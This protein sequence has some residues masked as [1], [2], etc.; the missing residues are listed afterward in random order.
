M[1]TDNDVLPYV[2]AIMKK[3]T[4]ISAGALISE[5]WILT[6]GDALYLFRENARELRVRLGSI[7]YRRGGIL[8]PIKQF[9]IHPYF[10]DTSPEYDIAL[11]KLPKPVRFTS[12]IYPIRV[13]AKPKMIT[14]TH[15]IVTSWP[16]P[17]KTPEAR[18]KVDSMETIKRRRILTISHLHPSDP[19]Q[20]LE[21]M[22]G[23]DINATSS[24]MC[25]DLPLDSK[26]CTR[27]V[28][29][30][31]V[32]NGILW[33]IISSYKPEDCNVSRSPSFVTLVSAPDISSWI[34]AAVRGH[35]WYKS[36]YKV[37]V[38]G[39]R[40]RRNKKEIDEYADVENQDYNDNAI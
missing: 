5:S 32:L 16:A 27:D 28:G 39:T 18:Q 33:G 22:D 30:P 9:E 38:N 4:Y 23:L 2:A 1:V 6:G 37:V 19:E 29:A 36:V 10:R 20:C 3:S 8:L 15:F 13:Q 25:L 21:E 35:R 34:H 12:N 14:A 26:S 17:L 24:L 31:V 40:K 7:N 11:M